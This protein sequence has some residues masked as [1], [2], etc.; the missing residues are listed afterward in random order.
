M[1]ES[2]TRIADAA[3]GNYIATRDAN[4][5]DAGANAREITLVDQSTRIWG[6]T[7]AS[8]T[9]TITN[10][11]DPTNLG[12]D[13][14]SIPAGLISAKLT[15]GDQSLLVVSVHIAYAS[16]SD[17]FVVVPLIMDGSDNVLGIMEPK[18]VQGYEEPTAIR[19]TAS[20]DTY[21]IC[22]RLAWPIN[23]AQY[24]GIWFR[25]A[26]TFTAKIYADLVSGYPE[27]V[28][29]SANAASVAA[30]GDFGFSVGG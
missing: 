6:V 20:G 4:E 10:S 5:N 22:P 8:P 13:F 9:R 7:Y 1:A 23:G 16:S 12:T 2:S 14:A 11:E 15:V 19:Y 28:L 29:E 26:A 21:I 24:I 25:G 30:V 3:S 27:G 18:T 17:T